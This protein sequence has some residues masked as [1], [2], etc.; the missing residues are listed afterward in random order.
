MERQ[1]MWTTAPALGPFLTLLVLIATRR[2]TE[3]ENR[4]ICDVTEQP[5]G[6]ASATLSGDDRMTV[7]T[8]PAHSGATVL[9]PFLTL[10]L[11]FRIAQ[12]REAAAFSGREQLYRA[13]FWPFREAYCAESRDLG[14]PFES[15]GRG[16][17]FWQGQLIESCPFA[18]GESPITSR[19]EQG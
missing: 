15:T 16:T 2:R 7:G 19:C 6:P 12:A 17:S 5:Q 8:Y 14:S 10:I 4:T 11:T 1:T 13:E 3:T 9:G 18:F